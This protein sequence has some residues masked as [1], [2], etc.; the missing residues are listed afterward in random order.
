LRIAV[1][2]PNQSQLK[3]SERLGSDYPSAIILTGIF[4]FVWF[5]T[6][7]P[8][9]EVLISLKRHALVINDLPAALKLDQRV[10]GP[11]RACLLLNAE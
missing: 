2:G 5:N 9:N 4:I 10:A 1:A 3:S 7:S 11:V 6:T 8:D